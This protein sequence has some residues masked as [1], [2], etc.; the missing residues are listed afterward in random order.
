METPYSSQIKD[1]YIVFTINSQ[2]YSLDIVLATSYRFIDKMY[3]YLDQVEDNNIQASLQFKDQNKQTEADYN[4][5]IGEFNNELLNV[6]FRKQITTQNQ[7]IREMLVSQAL[8]AANPEEMD[9]LVIG[10]DDDV[11]LTNGVQEDPLGITQS[12][13]DK[14]GQQANDNKN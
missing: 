9:A 1:G 2:I 13:E 4:E 14:Y 10:M 8:F 6:A 5:L 11:E 3:V 12:W 7:N